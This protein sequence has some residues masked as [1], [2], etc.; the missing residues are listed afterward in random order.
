MVARVPMVG[1]VFGRLTVK[2]QGEDL[3]GGLAWVCEC[4]CGEMTLVNGGHLRRGAVQSCG[5]L[6]REPTPYESQYRTHG[7]TN[8]P[9]Y[10]SWQSMHQRCG[11][12]SSD[13]YPIYGGRGVKV[14][15]QWDRFE[16][17][18]E[19]MGDRPKGFTLD[20]IDPDGHYQPDNCR[21]ASP[22][23]Q[24]NNRRNTSRIEWGGE[25]LT[26]RQFAESIGI[27]IPG[28]R[29]RIK[30]KF[31]KHADGVYRMKCDMQGKMADAA[32]KEGDA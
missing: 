1:K 3:Y 4:S 5:C 18:H 19:D 16:A 6:K 29:N 13:Q 14:C 26:T 25:I 15:R 31:T 27:S 24:A 9:T 10:K 22:K 8:T 28:A 20:R 32:I 11:N 21:W 12:P 17:F 23:L 2:S 7:M 30:A